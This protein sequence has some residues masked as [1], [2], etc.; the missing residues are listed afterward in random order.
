MTIPDTHKYAFVAVPVIGGDNNALGEHFIVTPVDTPST[1]AHPYLEV[2]APATLP[3][4]G[5]DNI[6]KS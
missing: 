5:C 2:V 1:E 3:E 6:F 4:V